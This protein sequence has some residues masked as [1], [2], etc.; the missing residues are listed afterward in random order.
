MLEEKEL[1]SI[2]ELLHSNVEDNVNIALVIIEGRE[3]VKRVF[4]E[5]IK[6]EIEDCG[7]KRNENLRIMIFERATTYT[8]ARL[9]YLQQAYS[10]IYAEN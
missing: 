10:K 8:N 2:Y 7:G 1:E 5:G 9:K 3:D 6:L 4:D